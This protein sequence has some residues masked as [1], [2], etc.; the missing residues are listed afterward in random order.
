MLRDA[1][2]IRSWG[3]SN[4]DVVDMEDL[5]DLGAGQEVTINQVLYN[6]EYRGIEFDLLPWCERRAI[7]VREF[8]CV[9]QPEV[10]REIIAGR[11]IAAAR[12]SDRD[13]A[14]PRTAALAGREND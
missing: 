13:P 11:I 6:L 14:R 12:F 1:A 5:I 9:A 7:P 8:G 3:V 4:F 10:M 2:K